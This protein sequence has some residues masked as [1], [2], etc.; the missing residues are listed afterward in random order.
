LAQTVL[1][2][3]FQGVT[4]FTTG[5]VR[6][7]YDLGDALLIVATDRISAFDVVLPTGIPD[8]GK[9]LTQMSAFWFDLLSDVVPNHMITGRTDVIAAHMASIGHP[10]DDA[11]TDALRGR[12]LLVQK[13]EAIPLECVVRGYLAGSAWAEYKTLFAHGGT[14]ILQGHELPVGLRESDK[15]PEPL[16]T[17]TTKAS[18]GHDM[19]LTDAEAAE[20]VGQE[21][22]DTLKALSFALYKRASEYA[23]ERGIIIADTKFEFG[24]RSDGTIILID[25]AFTPDSSR[26]WDAATFAPGQSQ[27]AIDKQFVRDYL[28]T[29]DWDRNPPGPELPDEVVAKTTER[30]RT[31]YRRITGRELSDDIA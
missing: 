5:K 7:V 21:T 17:P 18:A 6:D 9:V 3:D 11:G 29:L 19:P 15:L 14:V 4:R 31:A 22:F 1:S 12:S 16:F 13:C 26:F 28:L 25:E 27:P 2:T 23:A 8:K 10:I 30:Y 20:L 24:K